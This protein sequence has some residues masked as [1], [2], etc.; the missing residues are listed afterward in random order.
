MQGLG[1]PWLL[2]A[3]GYHEREEMGAIRELY[4]KRDVKGNTAVLSVVHGWDHS[5]SKI[6][7]RRTEER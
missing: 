2:M 3:L 6:T 5:I 7:I 1:C 4:S